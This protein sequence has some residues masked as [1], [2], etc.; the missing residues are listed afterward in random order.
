[1]ASIE[2]IATVKEK[3][4]ERQSL[5]VRRERLAMTKKAPCDEWRIR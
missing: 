3:G 5:V 4:Q 1:M 2:K